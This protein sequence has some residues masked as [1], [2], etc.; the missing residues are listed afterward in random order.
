MLI[1][2]QTGKVLLN[3]VAYRIISDQAPEE[4]PI[5]VET[6]DKYLSD[7]DSFTQSS[8]SKDEVLGIGEVVVVTTFTKVVFP[9][10][11]PILQFL[12]EKFTEAFQAE[13]GEE[14]VSWVKKLFDPQP[15]PQPIFTQ[16][17]LE[18]IAFTIQ[19][20]AAKEAKRLGLE[21]HQ[22]RTVSDAVIARLALAKK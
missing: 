14:A 6:R 5:Y 15:V 19:D 2:T 12:L 21:E 1:D 8:R 3:E 18:V 9:I 17:E 20:I 4:L 13:L 11:S 10:I 22:A 7:P 16:S